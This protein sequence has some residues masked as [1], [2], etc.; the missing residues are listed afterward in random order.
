MKQAFI[1]QQMMQELKSSG[2]LT[3]GAS[4][5]QRF[6]QKLPLTGS[7]LVHIAH[8]EGCEDMFPS[9]SKEEKATIAADG[10]SRFIQM[11]TENQD[12]KIAPTPF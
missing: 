9:L 1:L 11:A 2:R 8:E 3:T 4:L 10:R 7:E 12:G 5:A 6:H